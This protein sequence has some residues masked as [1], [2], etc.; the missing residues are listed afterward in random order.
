ML[1]YEVWFWD[2]NERPAVERFSSRKAAVEY[3]N[4]ALKV[5][6]QT[7]ELHRVELRSWRVSDAEIRGAN[8][9]G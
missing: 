9:E 8:K 2:G 1:E 7:V 4:H 6:F 3:Y 5:K